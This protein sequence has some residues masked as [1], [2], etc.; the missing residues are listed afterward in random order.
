MLRFK[1]ILMAVL[2]VVA[3]CNPGPR[4]TDAVKFNDLMVYKQ[5][6]FYM[7][8]DAFISLLRNDANANMVEEKYME[9]LDYVRHSFEFVQN[10]PPFDETDDL[11][12]AAFKYFE[13]QKSMMENEFAQIVELYAMPPTQVTV[14]HELQWDSLMDRV[15]LIDSLAIEEFLVRQHQFA[16]RYGISLRDID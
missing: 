11:R 1:F 16:E 6:T 10:H 2:F 13:K 15:V 4:P 8:L 9:T 14:E 5:D 3:A 7:H 12:S